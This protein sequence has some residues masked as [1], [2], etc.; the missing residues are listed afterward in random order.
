MLAL[1]TLLRMRTSY[2]DD[3]FLHD[4]EDWVAIE[5]SGALLGEDHQA[6]EPR[7]GLVLALRSDLALFI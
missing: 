5:V 3:P 6:R 4:V 1:C 2:V 7:A